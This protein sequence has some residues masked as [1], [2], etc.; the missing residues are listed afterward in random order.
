MWSTH[1][2]GRSM[3]FRCQ[4]DSEVSWD[5]MT[6]DRL[7][8]RKWFERSNI[9]L[10]CERPTKKRAIHP[11][12]PTI[13]P[14]GQDSKTVWWKISSEGMKGEWGS[15][16]DWRLLDDE[17]LLKHIDQ[18]FFFCLYMR[19]KSSKTRPF[20]SSSK[21]II[22]KWAL[23]SLSLGAYQITLD[24]RDTGGVVTC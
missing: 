15:L 22:T 4:A 19:S 2:V 5:L 9:S 1:F 12:C 8:T 16:D 20:S 18:V 21:E 11:S 13:H 14:D 6:D 3:S 10:P 17:K 23:S 24:Q 7:L